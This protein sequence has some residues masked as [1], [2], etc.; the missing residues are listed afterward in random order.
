VTLRLSGARAYRFPTVSELFQGSFN[1]IALIN[2]DPNLKPENDLSR[3]F[4]AEWYRP[5]GVARFTIYRSDTRNT[6]FS[7]TDTT[8][9]PNVTSVQN[10]GLVR[11]R[12][13]EASYDGTGVWWST[14]DLTA[15][16]AYT[17]ATTVSNTR[18]PASEG[19]QF[20]R[21]PRWRANLI[22][23]YH[24]TERVAM[25]LA[26]RYSGR[27]YNTL[28]HSDIDPDTFGGA[29]AFL[30][31]DAKLT[32]KVSDH[33]ELG[34]GV[35]NITNRRYYVYYPYPSRSYLVEARFRL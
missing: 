8:V 12:G 5:N 27:Q 28:D 1:G 24:A 4:S 34:A 20:Y 14:F 2:N 29:S 21:I 11:T 3:E 13:A 10:V 35:D 26:G 18:N 23:T 25:T 6:L 30:T 7:Q 19:K 16:A 22:G 15:N 33:V 31:F 9:F 17:Q 32:W